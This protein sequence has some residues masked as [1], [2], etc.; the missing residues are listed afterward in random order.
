MTCLCM[1]LQAGQSFPTVLLFFYKEYKFP[2]R[3]RLTH[4]LGDALLQ[5]KNLQTNNQVV[6]TGSQTNASF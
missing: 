6:D 4:A 2:N 5:V 3:N 1:K